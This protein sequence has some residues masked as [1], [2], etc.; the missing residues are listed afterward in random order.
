L[1]GNHD[2]HWTG[3]LAFAVGGLIA[4]GLGLTPFMLGYHRAPSIPLHYQNWMHQP[5]FGPFAIAVGVIM[6]LLAVFNVR[7]VFDS[8]VPNYFRHHHHRHHPRR[9]HFVV[10]RRPRSLG[11]R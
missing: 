6:I 7:K 11:K 2:K 5:V 4:I 3:R 10:R 8:A 9:T 1:S